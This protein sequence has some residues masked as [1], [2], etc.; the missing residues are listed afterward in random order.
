M[1]FADKNL[2]GVEDGVFDGLTQVSEIILRHNPI[3]TLPPGL[4]N[5]AVSVT[6]LDLSYNN[7]ISLDR[8]LFEDLGNLTTLDL[9]H[10]N[11]VN[12]P[13]GIFKTNF[14][15]TSLDLSYN[16]LTGLPLD[17]LDAMMAI[18]KLLHLNSNQ[19][20]AENMPYDLFDLY[21]NVPPHSLIDIRIDSNFDLTCYPPIISTAAM[22]LFRH[23]GISKCPP[24]DTVT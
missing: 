16:K 19:L 10:N 17:F 23:D 20:L 13:Y 18:P 15:V 8:Y 2:A 1:D 4:F 3:S 9:S 6:S 21:K 22:T 5:R 7:L 14:A 24:P 12:L 11:L